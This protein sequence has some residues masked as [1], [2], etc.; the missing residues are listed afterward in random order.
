MMAIAGSFDLWS[1]ALE[2]MDDQLDY[3]FPGCCKL[4]NTRIDQSIVLQVAHGSSL[5]MT[6]SRAVRCSQKVLIVT[7]M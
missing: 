6:G 7:V 4:A 1:Q 5:E 2:A 3:L